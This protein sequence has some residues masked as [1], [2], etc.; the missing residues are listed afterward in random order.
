[1][2]IT[3]KWH[4]LKSVG[5]WTRSSPGSMLWKLNKCQQPP[6]MPTLLK[7]SMMTMIKRSLQLRFRWK[8]E[9][10]AMWTIATVCSTARL[11][12]F[13]IGENWWNQTTAEIWE[14]KYDSIVHVQKQVIPILQ[15][16]DQYNDLSQSGS[17]VFYSSERAVVWP[18]HI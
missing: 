2:G 5:P 8:E 1:M 15:N 4:R 18:F 3:A 12:Q 6:F 10:L 16:F 7:M 17:S 9:E 11:S 13:V 14:T